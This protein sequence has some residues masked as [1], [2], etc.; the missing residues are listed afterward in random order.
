MNQDEK[1]SPI[2][3][4]ITSSSQLEFIPRRYSIVRDD[5]TISNYFQDVILQND[6]NAQ[7]QR[8]QA[9]LNNRSC[10]KSLIRDRVVRRITSWMRVLA[11]SRGIN[12]DQHCETRPINLATT[13]PHP[14]QQLSK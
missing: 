10:R 13:I 7:L 3:L 11:S 5:I 8:D 6:V 9:S 1:D 2:T 4:T 14:M 12:W